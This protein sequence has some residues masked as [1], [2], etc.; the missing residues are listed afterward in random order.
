[1]IWDNRTALP[2]SPE[3]YA[4]VSVYMLVASYCTVMVM[5]TVTDI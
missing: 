5:V 3:Q 1:M 2:A 4:R